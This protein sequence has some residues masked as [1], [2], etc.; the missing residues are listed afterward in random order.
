MRVVDVDPAGVGPWYD[1]EA[2]S[3][4]EELADELRYK[5]STGPC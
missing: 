3:Y 4:A 2:R 5:P 1:R